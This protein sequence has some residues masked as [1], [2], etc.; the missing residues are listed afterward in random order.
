MLTNVTESHFA[1]S[2]N[3]KV[4]GALELYLI[5]ENLF[6]GCSQSRSGEPCRSEKN[7]EPD[8]A[9]ANGNIQTKSE[10]CVAGLDFFVCFSSI[11]SMLGAPGQSCYA[12]ANAAL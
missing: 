10:N 6:T 9:T 2:Y 1:E 7:D 11:V 8:L 12:S 3:P 4:V 5:M